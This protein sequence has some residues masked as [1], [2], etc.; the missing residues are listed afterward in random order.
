MKDLICRLAISVFLIACTQ[1]EKS[2]IEGAWKNV[3]FQNISNDSLNKTII[4]DF[5]IELYPPKPYEPD[6]NYEKIIKRY[7]DLGRLL[8]KFSNQK[9]NDYIKE[10]CQIAEINAITE[11]KIFKKNTTIKE[12]KP[13]HELISSHTARK[14]FICLA[15]ERGLDV[16]MIKAI[17][18]I[19]REKTL[20]RYLHISAEKKKEQ[21]T[22]AF[23]E[24]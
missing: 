14:T 22:A 2:P 13:K 10:A 9:L 11:F 23:G 18:G 5:K 12:Y 8:P 15:Y 3:F 4:I 21:L 7:P 24:L 19:T 20:K 1:E 16:E 17:T 6:N